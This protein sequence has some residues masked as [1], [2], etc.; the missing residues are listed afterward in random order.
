MDL[1]GARL[2]RVRGARSARSTTAGPVTCVGGRTQWEVGGRRR[3]PT[4][5]RC[6]AP[7]GI[8]GLR[9]GRDDRAGAGRHDGRRPRRRAGRARADGRPARLAAAR[10]SAACWPSA[11][12]GCAASATGP[13]ATRC[14]RCGTCRPT[15][16]LVKAG[17]P[18]VKNV[19]GFDLCRLLVGS[20]GTLG[21]HRRGGAA[22]AGRSPAADAWVRGRGRPVRRL[23]AG[24]T[25]RPSLLWDGDA[26]RGCCS[27]AIRTTSRPRPALIGA[28]DA[29]GP[30]ALPP[31]RW[32]LRPAELRALP[33]R[34]RTPAGSWPRS[35]SAS[36]TPSGPRRPGARPGGAR[37]A[38]PVQGR[39]RPDRP[40]QPRPGAVVTRSPAA[41]ASTTTSWR[42]AWR[43]G[44]A[45]RTARPTG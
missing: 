38:P 28:A 8:V 43:A 1:T 17:G 31:H 18:T 30:P 32:S 7:A 29:D 11:A 27:R 41:R 2:E 9:A 12:A 21:V 25:G 36:C 13:C 24:C 19:S 22:H 40:P 42:R 35:A 37:P 15:G 16:R 20:L 10:P 6:G 45:C 34:R 33:D 44:C 3:A 4:R 5:A 39:L 26:P 14:S 23:R